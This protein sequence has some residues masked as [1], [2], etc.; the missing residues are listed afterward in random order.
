MTRK[1]SLRTTPRPT[2]RKA[3]LR[4]TPRS[5]IP[6]M[7]PPATRQSKVR[8]ISPLATRARSADPGTSTSKRNWVLT[9]PAPVRVKTLRVCKVFLVSRIE[10]LDLDKYCLTDN[11]QGVGVLLNRYPDT[12][13]NLVSFAACCSSV[14]GTRWIVKRSAG[15]SILKKFVIISS[16]R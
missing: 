12:L 4:T 6:R 9:L 7:Q 5:M 13:T 11:A 10:R 14:F 8:T 1:I 15:S 16:F 2:A 3:S